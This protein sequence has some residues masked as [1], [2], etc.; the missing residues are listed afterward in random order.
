M[1]RRITR[2]VEGNRF[3]SATRL[4][5]EVGKDI[6]IRET[7]LHGRSARKKPY[8]SRQHRQKRLAYAKKCQRMIA[9]D[10][11]QVML[12]DEAMRIAHEAFAPKRVLP[13]F[14]SSRK[15]VMIWGLIRG[16]GADTLHI[17]KE[18]VMGGYYC[19][20][21]GTEGPITKILNDLPDP[22][23]KS[24]ANLNPF[25]NIWTILKWEINKSP[26]S[27]LDELIKELPRLWPGIN[28]SSIKR[29]VISMPQ[30]LDAVKQARGGHTKY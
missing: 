8:L 19:H 7:G 6:G 28:D 22:R 18:S 13:T 21:L 16:N 27:L 12:T 3:I 17:C 9:D 5:A 10:W 1:D 23:Q 14:K 24:S 26:V 2:A 20:V 25:D 30:R 4:A 29:S 15:S 11:K